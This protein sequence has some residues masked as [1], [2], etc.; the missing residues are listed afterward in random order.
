MSDFV[1]GRGF[2][3]QDRSGPS[4]AEIARLEYEASQR[5]EPTRSSHN[6][7]KTLGPIVS[8]YDTDQR[9]TRIHK[10]VTRI[11]DDMKRLQDWFDS[12]P[13]PNREDRRTYVAILRRMHH[14]I[15]SMPNR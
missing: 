9:M 15:D 6:R 12:L 2:A 14:A 11:R 4:Q 13:E 8:E 3:S 1:S 10:S 5:H 7:R